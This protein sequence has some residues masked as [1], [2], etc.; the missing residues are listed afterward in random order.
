[1]ELVGTGFSLN[2]NG[3]VMGRWLKRD[4]IALCNGIVNEKETGCHYGNGKVLKKGDR[5]A[6]SHAET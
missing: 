3:M 6:L 1:M 2:G 4:W 5:M